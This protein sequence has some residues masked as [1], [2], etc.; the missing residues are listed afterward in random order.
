MVQSSATDV[1]TYLAEASA[2]RRPALHRLRE[3]CRSE[4]AGH[5]E[6]MAHGMPCYQREDTAEFA[7]ANQKRYLSL[8]VREDVTAAFA[9]RLAAHDMGKVCLR[10]RSPD[11]IDWSLVRDLLR[12]TAA[13]RGPVC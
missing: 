9:D 7:F 8:Y 2:E 3:M 5:T 11:H 4:L 1:D 6:T 13:T 10:F 12:A